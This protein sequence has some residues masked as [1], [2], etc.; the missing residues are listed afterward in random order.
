[1]CRESLIL[2]RGFL[3]LFLVHFPLTTSC[4]VTHQRSASIPNPQQTSN[5]QPAQYVSPAVDM[6]GQRNRGGCLRQL[7][8]LDYR[9]TKVQLAKHVRQCHGRQ[10]RQLTVLNSSLRLH[11]IVA[12]LRPNRLLCPRNSDTA[13]A[14]PNAGILSVYANKCSCQFTFS[15]YQ[16]LLNVPSARVPTIH[17]INSGP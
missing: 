1:M 10:R 9:P 2:G 12:L 16:P 4:S 7:K 8:R 14:K 3:I 15:E 17:W 13:A 6:P 5:L 11:N